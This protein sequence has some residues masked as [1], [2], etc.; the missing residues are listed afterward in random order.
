[1]D[2]ASVAQ[3]L[4]P[5]G[6][7]VGAAFLVSEDAVITC[8]HVVAL[9]GQGPGGRVRLAFPNLPGSPQLDGH[10][11]AWR[12][13]ED[14]DVAVLHLDRT[15][16]G[17]RQV[18]LGAAAG[19][20]GHR[21]SSFGFPSQAPERGHFGYGVAGDLLPDH[22][23]TDA[24][25]QLSAANDL[26]TGFSGGPVVDEATGLV[27]GMVTAI[28]GADRQ[29]RGL[30][31][32]YATP[33][34]V[35]RDVFPELALHQVCPY[36]GLDTFTAAHVGWFQGR[37]VAVEEALAALRGQPRVLL[38]L[39]PSGSGKSSLAQAGI[40][41]ALSKGGLPGSD[42]WLPLLARPGQDLPAE[43][44]QAGLPGSATE[45]IVPAV[46][47]RLAAAPSDA[48]LVVVIDQFEEL[49]TPQINAQPQEGHLAS[50]EQQLVDLIELPASVS[51][52]LILRDDFYPQLAA[53]A[54][55]L[56][57]AATPGL[58]NVPATLSVQDLHAIITRP[59]SAVGA[60]L[61]DGLPERIITDVLAAAPSVPARQQAPVTLLPPLQLALSQLWERRQDGRLTHQ[62]YDQ[63]G[64]ISGSLATWCNTALNQLPVEQRS[65]AQ[66]ILTALVRPAD[67]AHAT[68]AT[69]R[70]VPLADLRSLSLDLVTPDEHADEVFDSVLAALTRYRIIATRAAPKSDGTP[71]Q[72]TAELIHDALIR[73]WSDLR[74]WVA[75][76]HQFHAW[77]HRAG[78]QQVWFNATGDPGDLLDGTD[79]AEGIAW[80]RQRG[81]PREIAVFLTA[82]RQRQQATIRRTRRINAAL[83][84]MLTLALVAGGYAFWQQHKAVFAQAVAES[85]QLA[86]QST[87]LMETDPDLASLLAVQA[88]H[89][90]ATHE[91]KATLYTAAALPVRHV[92]TGHSDAVSSVV[93]SHDG[94][95][96]VT[97]SHD[98]TVR[99][100]DAD[101]DA[102]ADTGK[103]KYTLDKQSEHGDAVA[104]SSDGLT[105]ATSSGD[106]TV[107]LRDAATGGVKHTIADQPEFGVRLAFSPDARTLAVGG[108]KTVQLW[109]VSTRE[110]SKTLTGLSDD[111]HSLAFSPDGRTLAT[112]DSFTV[113][114][115]DIAGEKKL[116]AL[117]GRFSQAGSIMF[118]P[119]GR[120]LATGDRLKVQ[121]WDTDSGKSVRTLIPETM[122][123]TSVAYSVDGRTLATGGYDGKVRLWD[124]STGES[125]DTLVG[126]TGPVYSLAFSRDRRSLATASGDKTVRIWDA[127]SSNARRTIARP[128][129]PPV[130]LSPGGESL[131][132]SDLTTVRQWDTD[133]GEMRGRSLHHTMDVASMAF[134]SSGQTLAVGADPPLS[135]QEATTLR[136]WNVNTGETHDMMTGDTDFATAVAFSPDGHTLATGSTKGVRLWNTED[137]KIRHIL[138]DNAFS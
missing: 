132:I 119:D 44:E 87:A 9:A 99:A 55:H 128:Y 114:L 13:P 1:M 14:E 135:G 15:P 115:W 127:A 40:L 19:C 2:T 125:R 17:A 104:L 74:D 48:R 7:T 100:W 33:T 107:R 113:Q 72:A 97:S 27:I 63:I 73:D 35:L 84:C 51:I 36:L 92:F 11:L 69:R 86:T 93:Y 45:G 82:S 16:A 78:E 136:L 53:S 32:A 4:G 94:H 122:G 21:I 101:T 57:R 61:E 62:A 12:A 31:I 124:V 30:G 75:A 20:T 102:D 95:T 79:L 81:L 129:P 120:T 34:R 134:S 109:N 25:L 138:P 56:L 8:A 110:L 5:D 76:D 91:A 46:Q 133:T 38:L 126:H 89:T 130:A 111:A 41:P 123:A 112:G 96:L 24:L 29:Q 68:P 50:V 23:G 108:N 6:T 60:H 22:R 137:R 64:G 42:R 80:S 121:L 10:V 106:K 58:L 59:A 3:V 39:G 66:R 28:T 103:V 116:R 90:S 49:L 67:D 117:S 118:S 98:E 52:I 18:K 131:A 26:T 77:L 71:G 54:P 105:L 37:E 65:A 83:A 47:H 88:H 43:L 70:H 85:R